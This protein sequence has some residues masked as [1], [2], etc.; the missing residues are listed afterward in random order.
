MYAN[1]SKRG[2]EDSGRM[3]ITDQFRDKGT[4]VY[5]MKGCGV[6]ISLRVS[7][8]TSVNE[9]WE[10][11]LV[12]KGFALP[13]PLSSSAQTRSEALSVLAQAWDRTEG[14]PTLNWLSVEEAL[15]AVRAL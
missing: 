10:I 1:E 14:L 15:S 4:M 11:A 12:A 3:R 7:E 5:D 2:S 13:A 9:P 8:R 6:R